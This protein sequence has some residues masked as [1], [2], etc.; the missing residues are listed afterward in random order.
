M[1]AAPPVAAVFAI[2][3]KVGVYAVLR[4]APLAF[5][6]GAVHSASLGAELLIAGGL[7]TIAFG[8]IGVLAAQGLGRLAGCSVLVSTGTTLAA[9]GMVLL[10]GGAPMLAGAL[11]YMA[12]STL[13]IGALFLMVELLEREQGGVAAMLAVTAEAYGFGDEELDAEE[14]TAELAATGTMTVLGLCFA[15]CA[16]L[17][18]GLPPLS[19][20][21]GKFAILSGMLNPGGLGAGD[22]AVT[23]LALAFTALLIFSGLATLVALLRVGIQTFW[24]PSEEEVPKV[25]LVEIAPVIALLAVTVVMTVEAQ[26]VMRYMQATSEALHRPD[27]YVE[28]VLGAPR[29]SREPAE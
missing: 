16:L 14:P 24:A 5:G 9:T 12:S 26:P 21:V 15:G 7:A 8:M 17:L 4:V 22:P 6:A 2:M 29:V 20:F 13:A 1:A 23:P 25:L 27:V 10:G 18:A 3:S 19:G 11:Y 28:G